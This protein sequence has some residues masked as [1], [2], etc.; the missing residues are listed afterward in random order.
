PLP[1]LAGLLALPYLYWGT[2]GLTTLA[3]GTVTLTGTLPWFALA[4]AL[5]NLAVAALLVAIAFHRRTA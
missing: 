2:T 3:G 4:T 1:R 5:A